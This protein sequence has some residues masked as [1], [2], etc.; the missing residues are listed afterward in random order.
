MRSGNHSSNH[1][2][3]TSLAEKAQIRNTQVP[4]TITFIGA[5]NMAMS[6]I[7]GLLQQGVAPT[8]IRATDPQEDQLQRFAATGITTFTSNDAGIDGADL[9]VLAVKPQLAA[10]VLTSLALSESQ[11]LVSIAA[12]ISLQS[13][14]AWTSPAQPIVRCMPN[15]PALV[16][17]GM[18]A[19]FANAACNSAQQQHAENLLAAAG[20]VLWVATEQQLD[21]VTAVSGSGP[22]YFFYLMEAMIDAGTALG[23]ERTLATQLT[24]QTAYG[25]AVMAQQGEDDPATLRHNVTSPGG[26]TQAA[27]ELMSKREL[28]QTV[29]AA[30]TAAATRSAE[31]AAEF[32]AGETP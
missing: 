20:K 21:A 28:A 30:L 29:E 23:L 5:G 9:V 31:L 12:G 2:Q 1:E 14:S 17:A 4:G 25:A 7:Q 18:T 6:L 22:A 15:T 26:T 16:G 24:L 19:L 27:L 32:G 10:R 3:V 13:L 8:S 11:L